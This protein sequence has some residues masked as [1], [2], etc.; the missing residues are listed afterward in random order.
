MQNGTDKGAFYSEYFLR[1]IPQICM[2]MKHS[3]SARLNENAYDDDHEPNL[4]Q[5]SEEHPLPDLPEDNVYFKEIS[6]INKLIH[7]IGPSAKMVG[8]PNDLCCTSSMER[9]FEEGK[10]MFYSILHYY[11]SISIIVFPILTV[12]FFSPPDTSQE[13]QHMPQHDNDDSNV[14]RGTQEEPRQGTHQQM[15]EYF[16]ERLMNAL[17]NLQ[18]SST[19]SVTHENQ[20]SQTEHSTAQSNEVSSLVLGILSHDR[21]FS[22]AF[23]DANTATSEQESDQIAN[24]SENTLAAFVSNPL[25]MN[26]LQAWKSLATAQNQINSTVG[27][28]HS[29]ANTDV[30]QQD[31]TIVF[32]SQ[33][34]IDSLCTLIVQAISLGA[35][36]GFEA[37]KSSQN[38]QDDNSGTENADKSDSFSSD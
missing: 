8:M 2:M 32:P 33:L 26:A 37:I 7:E 34:S 23:S 10:Y 24:N 28:P 22:S 18:N 31:T 15:Q 14:A 13:Q 27:S 5:I 16:Q 4:L 29:Q 20:S 21:K 3:L 12:E 6:S 9:D 1:G 30:D 19:N 35:Q 11:Y 36:I 38:R 25:Y 17:A